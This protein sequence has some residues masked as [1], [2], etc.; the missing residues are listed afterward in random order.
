M[1]CIF[2]YLFLIWT[3]GRET[4]VSCRVKKAMTYALRC[5]SARLSHFRKRRQFNQKVFHQSKKKNKRSVSLQRQQPKSRLTSFLAFSSSAN[6]MWWL[7]EREDSTRRTRWNSAAGSNLESE[8]HHWGHCQYS[9]MVL[10]AGDSRKVDWCLSSE[11]VS[12]RQR[13]TTTVFLVNPPCVFKLINTC[14]SSWKKKM[15]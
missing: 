7:S 8:L 10:D 6:L 1:Y 2:F 15:L 12:E 4:A 5:L 13:Q 11:D 14:A 9:A 3:L